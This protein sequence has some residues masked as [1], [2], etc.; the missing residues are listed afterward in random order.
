MPTTQAG[1]REHISEEYCYSCTVPLLSWNKVYS[2]LKI[3]IAIPPV[4]NI[5][6]FLYFALKNLILAKHI[7]YEINSL[8]SDSDY[9]SIQ[10]ENN[11]SLTFSPSSFLA[12]FQ[13]YSP[14]AFQVSVQSYAHLKQVH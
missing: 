6:N 3:R 9:L 8:H 1:S 7:I 5:T 11:Y 14:R 4:S 2:L 10:K 12:I 13:F